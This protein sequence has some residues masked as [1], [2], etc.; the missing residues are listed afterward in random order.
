[1]RVNYSSS[2]THTKGLLH[3]SRHV[4]ISGS[5]IDDQDLVLPEK[6]SSQAHQLS[7]AHTEV[8]AA[9]RHNCFQLTLHVLYG[10]PQLD[11]LGEY[12]R[13]SYYVT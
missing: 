7:L 1:M 6:G 8:R 9:F 3:S 13:A 12:V 5:L 2:H 11:L 10:R 4:H